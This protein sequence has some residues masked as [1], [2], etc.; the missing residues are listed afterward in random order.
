MIEQEFTGLNPQFFFGTG[1]VN[2]LYSSSV[3]NPGVDDT[4]VAPFHIQALTVPF[5][6][7][8]N[9]DVEATLKEV[10]SVKIELPEGIRNAVITAR[11]K[12]TG[13]FFLRIQEIITNSL[14]GTLSTISGEQVY[15]YA[16]STFIFNPYIAEAFINNAFNPLI[17]NTNLSKPNVVAQVVDRSTNQA[18]PTN[19]AAIIAQGATPAQIQNCSY[20]KAGSVNSKYKGTKLTS[21]SIPGDDPGLLL[22]SF[23]GS[24]HPEGATVSTIKGVQLS[25]RDVVEVY[26]TPILS[27]SHPTK[28]LSDFPLLNTFVYVEEDNRLVRKASTK[29]F[30]TD[31]GVVYTTDELGEVISIS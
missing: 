29:I 24:I 7:K 14:P 23:K 31:K 25:D 12:R 6:S 15:T 1:N 30:S 28:K 20:T 22:R 2:L 18:I 4:P 9:I 27:G 5:T 26:F 13:Y 11:Q 19:L 21:G 3:V 16:D 17:N 10:T 8:N